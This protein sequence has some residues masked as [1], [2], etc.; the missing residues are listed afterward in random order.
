MGLKDYQTKLL[1]AFETFLARTRELKSPA[2][3]FA[4]STL[5]HFGHAL[6]YHP[7]PGADAVPYVCLRVPTGGGKTRIAGQA[8]AKVNKAFLATENSLVLWLVP[9]EPI[10]EQTLRALKTKGELLN[11]DMCALFGRVNVLDVEEAL[12]MTAPTLNA[13]NTIVVATMQS[14]KRDTAD[15]LRVYRQN[16]ALLS[17]FE[18]LSGPQMGERSLADVI[19]LRRPF[20]V[21]DEAH[22][23][24]TPLAVDTL[25]RLNPSCV[26]ELTA[27]PDRASQPSNVLRSVSA[28]TLQAEDMLKLPLELATHPEWRV[29]LSE[30]IGRLRSLEREAGEEVKLTGEV[31][32]PVVM[33]IQAE[34]KDARSETFTPERVKRHL[35]DDFNVAPETI[36]I[37]TGALD[38][39]SGRQLSDADYPQFI[40]TVDKLREGWDCPFAYILFSFRNTTS[41][42]AV[43]QVLGRILRMPHVSRK[44]REA[45]N[46]SYAYV[47]SG[48]LASTVQGLRDGLVQSG[49]ERLETKD[50]I[51]GPSDSGKIDDLFAGHKDLIVAL[52]EIGNALVLPDEGAIAALPKNVREK[53]EISPESGTLTIKGGADEA[54][55]RKISETFRQPEAARVVR[56]QLDAEIAAQMARFSRGETPAERGITA[57]VPLLGITQHGFFDV[58]NETPLLD[59]DWEISDFDPKLTESEFAHDVEA[60]RRAALSISQLEKIEC[61]VFD[62]LDSQLAL[63]GREQ[64]WSPTDLVHWL[65]RNLYFPYSDQGE[66]AAWLNAAVSYLTATRTFSIDEL[67]YRKFRLRGALERK[68]VAGLVLAK[69]RVFEGL[70]GDESSFDVRDEHCVELRPGRYAYDTPYVGLLPLKRHFFPVIGNLKPSGEEFECAEKIANELDGVEWWVRNVEK[71][72]SSFWLQTASDR[73]YP[74]FIVRLQSGVTLAVEYKGSHI[75]DGTDSKEKKRIGDLW[76]RRSQG[77]CKFVWVENRDWGVLKAAIR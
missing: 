49:F 40:I 36:A 70:F 18:G 66:K 62:R 55:I 15:G 12:A 9:S 34:R 68:M 41:A 60:M 38:E 1:E 39:L 51:R 64:G 43:E 42:T 22:N 29:S 71:K 69:Q 3:A 56:Q 75:A 7:L 6:P 77:R 63:F 21:V 45:L 19:R 52:P 67:A 48:E 74:D 14:F 2:A 25:V 28:S 50:L 8:I 31:I 47:V 46:R 26:L 17:H 73:F 5:A 23:Q 13:A 59:A 37:A 27:T 61:D 65:D 57:T 72:P 32:H 24:G 16:G 33:L 30:A 76:A 53:L 11:E 10:R 54:E 4:E 44:K 35:V 58:F 20:I